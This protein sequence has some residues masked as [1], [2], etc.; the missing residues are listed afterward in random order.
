[1]KRAVVVGGG[2]SGLAA[3]Y[4]LQVLRAERDLPLRVTL[5]EGSARLGGAIRTIHREGFLLE[6]GPD[7]F[8]GEDSRFLEFIRRLGLEEER[9]ETRPEHRRSFIVF[10]GRLR[11][12]PAGWYLTAPVRWTALFRMPGLSLAGRV[13]AACEPWIP[14]RRDDEDESVADWVRRRF[15]SQV[16]ERIAQPMLGGIHAAD[17]ARLSVKAVF[18]QLAAWE[19]RS[20]SVIR[21]LRTLKAGQSS[22]GH[23]SGARYR[24]F[25]S[26]RD[27]MERLV[28]ALIAAMPELEIRTGRPV[29][30]LQPGLSAAGQEGRPGQRWSLTLES[31]QSLKAD[32]VIL[33]V[34][35]PRAA[36]L[37]RCV[38]PQAARRLEE[39]PCGSVA[40]LHLAYAR[41]QVRHPMNGFGFVVPSAEKLPLVGCTFSHAKFPARA[42][43][44]WALL[45]VFC[46]GAF[47]RELMTMEDSALIDRV[48]QALERLLGI[49]GRPKFTVLHRHPASMPAYPVR[50]LERI[51]DL[52]RQIT[53]HP[54]LAFAGNA[55]RGVGIPACVAQ[56][57]AAAEKVWPFLGG[58]KKERSK[59]A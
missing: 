30:S 47:G 57:E 56:A 59:S 41:E 27:G 48:R 38:L 13:R 2:I 34:P 42:P 10:K 19:S 12:V 49:R 36:A 18:P 39:I 45:R 11:P 40:V 25:T 16:L 54:T 28:E 17:P 3:A 9:M 4:R 46:G 8:L 21:G 52:G 22:A 26:F 35:A 32:A 1:M 29:A 33:A 31:G 58:E 44:G 14:P 53:A 43:A 5:V 6:T 20:G 7:A 23:A 55:F 15:G 37:I 24:L 51:A 50:H